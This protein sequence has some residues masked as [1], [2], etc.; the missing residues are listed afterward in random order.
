MLLTH[1]NLLELGYIIDQYYLQ[2]VKMLCRTL[3]SENQI[4]KSL[5]VMIWGT[6]VNSKN[7]HYSSLCI[8]K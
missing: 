4:V 1:L 2:E 8:L 5:I 3:L 7:R 6:K